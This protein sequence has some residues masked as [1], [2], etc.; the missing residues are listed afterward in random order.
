MFETWRF[1]SVGLLR[2][3]PALVLALLICVLP[4]CD[5]TNIF[6]GE[7]IEFEP[8]EDDEGEAD[9]GADFFGFI[10][11]GTLLESDA[12]RLRFRWSDDAELRLQ[13]RSSATAR[14]RAAFRKAIA[15]IAEAGGPE[16]REVVSRANIVVSA[17][18]EDEYRALDQTRPWSFSRT[19]VTADVEAGITEVEIAVALDR[20]AA[21]L[22]RAALHALGHAI[23]IMGHPAVQGDQ[24]VMAARVPTGSVPPARFIPLER[25]AIQF[26]YSDLVEIGMTRSEL[27][28]RADDWAGR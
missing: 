21:T 14:E 27:A 11:Q 18:P 13:L 5:G 24:H 7:A 6:T 26:L 10:T 23:G 4:A 25:E 12:D 16:I 9:S 1:D 15:E 22:D 2:W 19:W 8:E 3:T 28:Q 20:D 17:F